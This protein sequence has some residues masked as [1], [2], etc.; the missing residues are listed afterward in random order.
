MKR[1]SKSI[2]SPLRSPEDLVLAVPKLL[3]FKPE[4]SLV[5][6]V[7]KRKLIQLTVR[8][9]LTD[10]G[11]PG[12][13][14]SLINRVLTR[15]PKATLY[16]VVI[17]AQPELMVQV[18]GEVTEQMRGKFLGDVI[19][20][21]DVGGG[22]P[23]EAP[24]RED[25][26]LLFAGP[27]VERVLELNQQIKQ[28]NA[29]LK[30]QPTVRWPQLALELLESGDTDTDT[31][32]KLALLAAHYPSREALIM[33]LTHE[34]SARYVYC[35]LQVLALTPPIWQEQ[36]LTILA[37]ACWVDAGGVML[38]LARDRLLRD[39]PNAPILPFLVQLHDSIVPPSVWDDLRPQLQELVLE[40]A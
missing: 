10:L 28:V 34:N 1:K 2:E 32:L 8:V 5:V 19:M 11:Q 6:V 20:V 24:S 25:L 29:E 18:A 36:V 16:F 4:E 38:S 23:S 15:F 39:F 17:S 30:K 40:A 33:Q 3:G 14:E 9:E 13:L 12:Y 22:K 21:A 37:L 7:T 31:L 27:S 35:W 26:E